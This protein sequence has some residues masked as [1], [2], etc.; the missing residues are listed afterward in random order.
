MKSK[1]IE[2]GDTASIWAFSTGILAI[3]IGGIILNDLSRRIWGSDVDFQHIHLSEAVMISA[4]VLITSASTI[5]AGFLCCTESK[6]KSAT[7]FLAAGSRSLLLLFLVMQNY[8]PNP[9]DPEKH[10]LL[11]ER[12]VA[13]RFFGWILFWGI[14]QCISF[15]TA[16]YFYSR[17]E[18]L[19]EV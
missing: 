2:K 18:R 12:L 14:A 10:I 11:I 1:Y 3:V 7:A 19:N 8:K 16:A 15:I 13:Y 4:E 9:T 17:A 5:V 6:Y